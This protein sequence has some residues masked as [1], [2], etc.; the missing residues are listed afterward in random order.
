MMAWAHNLLKSDETAERT[1]LALSPESHCKKHFRHFEAHFLSVYCKS[2][3]P[4]HHCSKRFLPSPESYLSTVHLLNHQRS[5]T[6]TSRYSTAISSHIN[7][8]H[9]KLTADELTFRH[10]FH[11]EGTMR[12][13]WL[14]A[15]TS[16]AADWKPEPL[17]YASGFKGT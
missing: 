11:R 1:Y 17:K 13:A 5:R 8:P 6:E 9:S 4:W 15:I 2:T 7:M 14:L 3:E 12:A 16:A 10:S